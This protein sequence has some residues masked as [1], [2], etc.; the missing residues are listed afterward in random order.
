[1]LNY[2]QSLFLMIIPH[3]WDFYQRIGYGKL[4]FWFIEKYNG[5]YHQINE[6]VISWR[7]QRI[8]LHNR[9]I[10]EQDQDRKCIMDRTK[11]CG[12]DIDPM[13]NKYPDV[14]FYRKW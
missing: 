7:K 11:A 3:P 6:D 2:I 12:N 8:E 13:S 14:L 9:M 5:I 10:R 1:M 4:R